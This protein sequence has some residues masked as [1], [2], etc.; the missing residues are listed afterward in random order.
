MG[1]GS[2]GAIGLGV[3]PVERLAVGVELRD[4]LEV[5]LALR[6]GETLGLSAVVGLAPPDGAGVAPDCAGVAPDCAGVAPD[7]AGVAPAEVHPNV[8]IETAATMATR[9]TDA[10]I[11]IPPFLMGHPAAPRRWTSCHF[12]RGTDRWL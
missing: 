1:V 4:V 6:P 2:G 10:L 11:D 7:C 9:R 5:G 12:G 8:Q 3:E